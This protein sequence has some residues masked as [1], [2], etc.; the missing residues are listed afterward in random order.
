MAE[1]V[2]YNEW[3]A[4]NKSAHI[5]SFFFLWDFVFLFC[6]AFS[7]FGFSFCRLAI[8]P[9][10]FCFAF[11]QKFNEISISTFLLRLSDLPITRHQFVLVL[12]STNQ[13]K[14]KECVVARENAVFI[15]D[16]SSIA[17]IKR[18]IMALAFEMDMICSERPTTIITNT[19]KTAA[20][21][22]TNGIIWEWRVNEWESENG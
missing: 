17:I 13:P 11:S 16:F 20:D 12:L 9:L 21:R 1:C 19:V 14:K 10:R 22:W 7:W 18:I 15:I 3:G 4:R 8:D 5:F 2:K 6:V